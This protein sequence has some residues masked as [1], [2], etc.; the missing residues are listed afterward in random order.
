M[1]VFSGPGKLSAR[2]L[3]S[4]EPISA[5]RSVPRRPLS[6]GQGDERVGSSGGEGFAEDF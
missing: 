1:K 5:R 4:N 6:L 2:K 3:K